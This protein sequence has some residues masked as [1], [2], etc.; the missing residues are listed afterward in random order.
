M[1]S[2]PNS[3]K[4]SAS[5]LLTA[6]FVLGAGAFAWFGMAGGGDSGPKQPAAIV[7][8]AGDT[9]PPREEA[10]AGVAYG[11]LP[12]RIVVPS[13]GVDSVISEVGIA[14]ENGRAVYE[15]AWRSAGHHLDSALP[16]QLGNMVITGHVS[17]AD[18]GNL[19]VFS[20]LDS[21]KAG[22]VVEVYSGD[23]AFRYTISKVLVVPPNAVKLLRSDSS[24]TLTLVTCTKDLKNRLIVV[25]TLT[26]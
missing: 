10:V 22:D 1:A 7:T 17:V 3:R 19:A 8:A 25:G 21:V 15:T 11:G 2:A 23:Q 20:D 6:A 26:A 9:R 4:L 5:T 13:A 16:G 24:S 14:Q 18:R 12:T